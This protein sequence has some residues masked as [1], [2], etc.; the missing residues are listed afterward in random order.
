[1]TSAL[2]LPF[3]FEAAALQSDLEKIGSDEWVPHF[4]QQYYEG[5]WSGVS[6]RSIG[7]TASQLYADPAKSNAYA[8]TPVLERCAYFRE[9]LSEF[10]CPLQTVR[11]L[12][13]DPGSRIHEHRDFDLGFQYGIVRVHVPVRTDT[14]TH[15]FLDGQRVL[16]NEGESWYLDFSLPHSIDNNGRSARIHLVI[17]C[18]VSEWICS[19]IDGCE[20]S[21]E[22]GAVENESEDGSPVITFLKEQTAIVRSGSYWNCM[23]AARKLASLL[24]DS[25]RSPWIARLRKTLK[26]GD[27]VFHAPLTPRVPGIYATWTSHYVC[28]CDGIAYDPIAGKAMRLEDYTLKMFGE[29]LPME[30]FVSTDQ[31]PN[32]LAGNRLL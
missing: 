9:V 13:L 22:W 26:M 23:V 16:M 10:K 28:C 30:V 29:Q 32:Y 20:S 5:L 11:L 7:G 4:N 3:T 6:L 19:V 1:M 27:E 8:D 24:I 25:G 31:L 2:K 21:Q 12:K 18:V 14:D 17:D 15:F